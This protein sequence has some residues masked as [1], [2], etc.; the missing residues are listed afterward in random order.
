MESARWKLLHEVGAGDALAK[1]GL[2][3]FE[4]SADD[5]ATY[6]VIAK[7]SH[8]QSSS[9]ACRLLVRQAQR[10]DGQPYARVAMSTA[11]SMSFV[12]AEADAAAEFVPMLV[13]PLRDQLAAPG[14]RVELVCAAVGQP[15]PAPLWLFG[16]QPVPSSARV[17]CELRPPCSFV[18]RILSACESDAGA[19]ALVLSNKLGERAV[20]H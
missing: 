7:N 17:E 5:E 13:E 19:Y 12:P 18:L 2:V 15:P 6:E 4:S 1:H 14:E 11:P 8:G 10:L 9:G 3:I 20:P 16:T